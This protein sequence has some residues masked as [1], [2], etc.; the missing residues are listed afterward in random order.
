MDSTYVAAYSRLEADHWW[1]RARARI[2]S[3][4]LGAVAPEGGWTRALDVGCGAGTFLSEL[5]GHAR[6]VEGLEPTA[7]LAA[8]AR[9]RG[10]LVHPDQLEAFEPERPYD[11]VTMMDVLEHI[12]DSPTA[13]RHLRRI[14]SPGATLLLT[15]PAMPALW[16]SHDVINEHHRRYTRTTLSEEL[17]DAGLVVESVRY[18][19]HWAAGAKLGQ[20]GAEMLRSGAGGT[21]RVPPAPLNRALAWVSRIDARVGGGLR[22]PFG[23][24]L[25]MVA[26]SPASSPVSSPPASPRDAR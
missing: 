5:A 17:R 26:T 2:V 11:L 1:W 12:E 7:A 16:T 10:Y 9:D 23:S 15:V 3:A 8:T 13:L 6:E 24:S 22:L 14:T 19:F 20:R 25:L 18:F 21:P 4:E